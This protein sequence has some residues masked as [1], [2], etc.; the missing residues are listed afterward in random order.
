MLA[1][2]CQS[3]PLRLTLHRE[4]ARSYIGFVALFKTRIGP[5]A[6]FSPLAAVPSA[7]FSVWHNIS[8]AMLSTYFRRMSEK[9][10]RA[11]AAKTATD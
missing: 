7:L 5:C 1:M 11:T 10:D 6:H 9:A 8:G 3:T 4:Q 2:V